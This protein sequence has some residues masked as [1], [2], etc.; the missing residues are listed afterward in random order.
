MDEEQL[1]RSICRNGIPME[2]K[3]ASIASSEFPNYVSGR[4]LFKAILSGLDRL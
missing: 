4:A 2:G 3:K 1:E